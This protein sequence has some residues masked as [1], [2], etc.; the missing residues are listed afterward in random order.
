MPLVSI[1][2][3]SYN[4]S[5]YISDTITSVIR[6]SFSDWELIV[7]DDCSKD[8]TVDIVKEFCNEDPRIKLISLESNQG[9]AVAR[10]TAI[11]ISEGRYI[12]F[13]DADD[14]WLPNK[15][16]VQ[17]AYMQKYN[18]SF[19]YSAYEKIDENNKHLGS[20][21]VPN[22]VSYN[23]LLKVC[24]IGC[25]TAMYDSYKLGK[26]YMPLIRKR[27]DL[28]LWLKLLKLEGYAYGIPNVLARYRVRSDSIS[29]N[30]FIAAQYTWKL[31]RDVEKLSLFKATYF[32]VFYTINGILR[33]KFQKVARKIG[34]LKDPDY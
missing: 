29:S 33:T 25:L 5:K 19:T 18:F 1:V 22:R 15:L 12:T 6:Q 17:V 28:G 16:S 24:S 4:S 27:Q 34:V 23:S 8:S 21:G 20:V 13:L 32:F 11:D 7:V 9:A 14:L 31:Y 3:P 2:T 26:V 30:K 10:N